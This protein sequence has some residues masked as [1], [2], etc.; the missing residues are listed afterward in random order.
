MLVMA[1]TLNE[2]SQAKETLTYLLQN[3][4][5]VINFKNMQLTPVKE[6]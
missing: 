3:L 1:Q 4:G 5:L 2:I 6:I